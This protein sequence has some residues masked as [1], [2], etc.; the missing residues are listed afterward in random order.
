[1]APLLALLAWAAAISADASALVQSPSASEGDVSALV[2][3][4]L[5][6][7]LAREDESDDVHEEDEE[8][9]EEEG[10][11]RGQGE[12]ADVGEFLAGQSADSYSVGSSVRQ[13]ALGPMALTRLGPVLGRRQ[14]HYYLFAGVRYAETPE[15]FEPAQ[16]KEPWAPKIYNGTG[17]GAVCT[18]SGTGGFEAE[19]CLRM[20]I[21]VPRKA[22][23]SMPV[24]V[25]FHGGI[26]Q[27]G[28]GSEGGRRGDGIT[29]SS[30]YPTIFVNFNW[31]LGIYGWID[32]EGSNIS[33]N[34]GL[35][36]QQAA[37]R[38]VKE[39]IAA[40][41]GDPAR[42]TLQGQSEGCGA[43]LVHLVA[44]GSAGLFYRAVWHSP[45]A[46]VWSRIA[47]SERTKFMIASAN[48]KRPSAWST[49]RCLKRKRTRFL[50]N[51][52][53]VA[54]ELSR[55]VMQP[56]W[57]TNALRLLSFA[58]RTKQK[59]ELIAM[60][61]W[62]AE[63]DNVTLPGNPVDLIRQGRF[64]NVTVLITTALNESHGVIPTSIAIAAK[65]GLK[66]LLG[67]L[68]TAE[69]A[70][71]ET[72]AAQ[73]IVATG[74]LDIQYQMLTDKLWTCDIRS[75]AADIVRGG[76]RAHVGMFAHA[77]KYSGTGRGTNAVCEQGAACHADEMFYVLPQGPRGIR[78]PGMEG[79]L[80]FSRRYSESFLAFVHGNDTGH[81][82][83]PYNVE[84]Q[85][86]TFYKASGTFVVP[87]YRKEQCD[88]LDRFNGP[89][90][91]QH[92]R[93]LGAV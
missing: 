60:L 32:L 74:H 62:H 54:E 17:F 70:Y 87:G 59:D 30:K 6:R 85:P 83:V 1:M 79:E 35:L 33:R 88:V 92:M 31:R 43:V 4:S 63:V 12:G 49:V 37:L 25:Y 15:R 66:Y 40:F 47:N 9:D 52:D 55:N 16:P 41:G 46:D 57:I 61:G 76:G 81:P 78:G 8:E 44:P 64:H 89:H 82:W 75:L 34:L 48:C 7:Q 2:Q 65:E 67:D 28:S 29:N 13:H 10:S 11:L 42:V 5:Q 27:H 73:G 84:T 45:V 51:Q 39:N 3:R 53:W 22:A 14:D 36:D 72:L 71:N 56:A 26:N 90:I 20:N 58:L 80:A 69:G 86:F 21:W 23:K 24:I 93:D 91:K 50:W 38:W 68:G 18:G 77:P 19:D